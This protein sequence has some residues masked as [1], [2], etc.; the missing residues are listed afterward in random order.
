MR[1][2]KAFRKELLKL[3]VAVIAGI[4]VAWVS[5]I[6]T[7]PSGAGIALASTATGGRP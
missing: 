1:R 6:E 4:G 5:G 3:A 2:K 7:R